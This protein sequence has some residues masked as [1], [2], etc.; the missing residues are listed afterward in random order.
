VKVPKGGF[1]LI[2]LLVVIAII[3]IL[4]AVAIPFYQ[5]HKIRAKLTEVENTMLIL[6]SA[7]TTY[8]Q[9]R[10]SWPDCSNKNE[11]Q[12]SLGV[13]VGAVSRVQ[14]ISVVNGTIT[15]RIQSID[16]MVD[17]ESLILIPNLNGDGSISWRWDWS[18]G[19]PIH[20]RPRT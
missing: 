20:L 5:G 13:A 19:F 4:T 14:E 9:E 15:I 7:V 1:T 6:K 3:G 11:V 16:A 8:H 10:D 12:N 2:E 18:A 17:G